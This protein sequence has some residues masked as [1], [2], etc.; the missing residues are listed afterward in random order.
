MVLFVLVVSPLLAAGGLYLVGLL[1]GYDLPAPRALPVGGRRTLADEVP[2]RYHD[3]FAA[4]TLDRS[5]PRDLPLQ[6]VYPY[7][8]LYNAAVAVYGTLVLVLV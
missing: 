5:E 3:A 1:Q 8:I 6:S 7:L 4:E 2:G